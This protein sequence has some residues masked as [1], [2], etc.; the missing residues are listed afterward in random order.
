MVSFFIFRSDLRCTNKI[1]ILRIIFGKFNY[2]ILDKKVLISQIRQFCRDN[3]NAENVI[4]AKR[5]FKE[6]PDC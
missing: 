2:R 6:A 3:A 5:Y 4:K 1:D